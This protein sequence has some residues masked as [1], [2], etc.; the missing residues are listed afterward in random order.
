MIAKIKGLWIAFEFAITLLFTNLFMYMF[1][2]KNYIIRKKFTKLQ[3]FLMGAKIKVKGR[4][5]PKT[6]L[7]L[8]NHQSLIDIVIFEDCDDKDKCWVA[9]KE[10]EDIPLFGQIITQPKMIGID[11]K[12]KRS[13]IKIIKQSKERIKEGRVITMF[14]EGTRGDS[15]KLLPFQ[16]GAKILANKLNLIVQPV[17]LVKTKDVLNSKKLT[18]KSGEVIV[19]YLDAINPKDNENWFENMQENMQKVLNAELANNTSHR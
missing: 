11:R 10:I 4:P 5:D 13:I 16:L 19:K 14:P 15:D 7:Y 17:V 9:K 12:D 3:S 8:L 6:K 1:N 18:C 2:K